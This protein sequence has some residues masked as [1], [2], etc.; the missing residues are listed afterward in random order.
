MADAASNYLRDKLNDHVHGG[1][2]FTPPATLY[3]AL[4]TTIPTAAGGGVEVSGGSYARVAVTNNSSNFPAASGGSKQNANAIDWGTAS[5]NWGNIVAVAWYD[6]S[7]GGNLI[8]FA[9]LT[10]PTTVNSGQPFKI[11]ANGATFTYN[12]SCAWSIYLQNKILDLVYSG[13][14]FTRP[15][16]TYIGLYL[17][18]PAADGTGGTEVSGGSYGRVSF[19]NNSANWPA[20][21]GQ[22]KQNANI[23]NWGTATGNWGAIVGIAEWDASSGGNMLVFKVLSNPTTVNSGQPF[24]L[25]VDGFQN[26]WQA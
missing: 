18:M 9:A 13:A 26:I 4:M 2:A 22:L 15:A 5:A 23:I 21:S 16:T 19:T 12:A 3:F 11:N 8:G 14:S 7:S 17:V 20:S 24:E 25:P 10:N 1:S 6:A